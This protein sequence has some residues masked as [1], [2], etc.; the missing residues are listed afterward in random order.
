MIQGS[1]LKWPSA[2]DRGASFCVDISNNFSIL[3]THS[4][5]GTNSPKISMSSAEKG[6]VNLTLNNWVASGDGYKQVVTL[7]SGYLF[8]T[9]MMKY[10]I[11]S[12]VNVGEEVCLTAKKISTNTFEIYTSFPTF[13]LKVVVA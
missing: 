12:G 1:F 11:A 2:G 7:P 10:I 6:V 8:D 13:D 4:H 5:N 9:S 3:D